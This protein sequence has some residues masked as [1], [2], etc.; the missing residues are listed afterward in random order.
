MKILIT[1]LNAIAAS[2]AVVDAISKVGRNFMD[3]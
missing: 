3:R 1:E 2:K